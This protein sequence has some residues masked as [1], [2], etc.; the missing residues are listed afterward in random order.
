MTEKL[1]S[2]KIREAESMAGWYTLIAW[3]G[4]VLLFVFAACEQ[5]MYAL[6][7]FPFTMLALFIA[8]RSGHEV[9]TCQVIAQA[10]KKKQ[11]EDMKALYG[12]K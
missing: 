10:L 6:V 2:P 1:T 12:G 3:I 4:C 11:E 7:T 9:N 5:W 8:I